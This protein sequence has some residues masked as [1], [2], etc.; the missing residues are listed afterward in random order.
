MKAKSAPTPQGLTNIMKGLEGL[1]LEDKIT[2]LAKRLSEV[3]EENFKLKVKSVEADKAQKNVVAAE[4]KL[5]SANFALLK[6]DE[7]KNKL[8]ELCRQ[9]QKYNKQ[10]RDENTLKMKAIEEERQGA[11]ENLKTTLKDIEKSMDEGREKSVELAGENKRLATKLLELNTEY[12]QRYKAIAEQYEKK[13]TYIMELQK[14]KDAE[15]KVLHTKLEAA[16]CHIEKLILEKEELQ[17]S[18]LEGSARVGSALENERSLRKEVEQYASRYHELTKSLS[19]SNEAFDSFKTEIAKVNTN[20]KR[21][22]NDSR[23][24]KQMYDEATNNV[25]VL[26]MGKKDLEDDL[27]AL[28]KKNSQLEQ[29]CRALTTRARDEGRVVDEVNPDSGDASA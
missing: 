18:L 27:A 13:E 2:K 26:T 7:Q 4:K 9:L 29:L 6:T 5:D 3:E 8:E 14:A 21:V 23:K 16:K 11:V 25:L 22:E 12:D 28:K 1:S 20:M 19:A 17:R 15:I 10:L 24:W